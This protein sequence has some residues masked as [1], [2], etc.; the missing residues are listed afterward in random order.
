MR[1]FK[2]SFI[3]VITLVIALFGFVGCKNNEVQSITIDTSNLTLTINEGETFDFSGLK[4]TAN[5]LK[6][7]A[8]IDLGDVTIDTALVDT[9]KAGEYVV[10]VSYK[11]HEEFFKVIVLAALTDIQVDTSNC[12]IAILENESLDLSA[13]K[14][15]AIYSDGTNRELTSNEYTL[16]QSA[17]V[18][19]SAGSYNVKVTYQGMEK[20][21][22]VTVSKEEVPVLQSISV[23]GA[24]NN[25][26][27]GEAFATTG[28]VVTAHYSKG[29]DK[30]VTSNATVVG[31]VEMS[32][33]GEQTVRI[34]YT[35]GGV[36]KEDTYVITIV[37]KIKSLAADV[38]GV[39]VTYSPNEELDLTGLKVVATLKDDTK[40]EL[41]GYQVA[42]L[43]ASGATISDNILANTADYTVKITYGG[44]EATFIVKARQ[45]AYILIS[46]VEEFLAMR[47]YKDANNV[48]RESYL[49]T[50]DL[51]F[52]DVE[53]SEATCPTFAGEFNGGGHKLSNITFA[54]STAKVGA[55][56]N[57]IDGGTVKNLTLFSC[58]ASSTAESIGLIG[59]LCTNGTF[60]DLEF[61]CCTV[62]TS[63]GSGYAALVAGRNDKAGTVNMKR[64]T[65]KNLT[66]VSAPKYVG[67]LIADV[68]GSST[69][70][71]N[72]VDVNITC[73]SG[74]QMGA[75]VGRAR[76]GATLNVKN[77]VIRFEIGARNETNKTGAIFDGADRATATIENVIVASCT[78]Q[79]KSASLTQS[80]LFKGQGNATVTLT[81]CFYVGDPALVVYKATTDTEIDA[82]KTY[83]TNVNGE[84][85]VVAEPVVGS[86]ASYYEKGSVDG[87]LAYEIGDTVIT[88]MTAIGF[89]FT[90]VWEAD[91]RFVVKLKGSSANLPSQDATVVKIVA[92]ANNAK[93][94]Y[95]R[96]DAFDPNGLIVIATYSD[97]VVIP[98]EESDYT[99]TACKTVEGNEVAFTDTF[100]EQEVGNY[101]IKVVAGEANAKYDIA[102]VKEVG[103]EVVAIEGKQVFRD[104][105][106]LNTSGIITFLKISDGTKNLAQA[107]QISFSVE[108]KDE[109]VHPASDALSVDSR[110]VVVTRTAGDETFTAKYPIY[111]LDNEVSSGLVVVYV[112]PET[113]GVEEG[114]LYLENIDLA[115]DYLRS[116]DLKAEVIKEIRVEKG[117]YYGAVVVDM[118]N[119]RIV[120]ANAEDLAS[121]VVIACDHASDTPK[122]NLSASFGTEGSATVTIKTSAIGFYAYGV[123]FANTFDYRHSEFT[124]KQAVALL[125][126]ADQAEFVE[127][128]FLG[129]QD[130]LEPKNGRQYYKDCYIEGAVDFIF[131]NNAIVI[132]DGCEIHNVTRY[133]SGTDTPETNQ[134]Y[135]CAPKGFSSGADTDAIEYGYVFMNCRFTAEADIPAGSVSIARPWGNQAKVAV[136]NSTLGAHISILAYDGSV[137]SRYADMSGNKPTDANVKF[138]EYN[139]TGDGAINTAVAGVTILTETEASNY[140]SAKIFGT[141]NG[142]VKY[143]EAWTLPDLENGYYAVVGLKK[144]LVVTKAFVAPTVVLVTKGEARV[145]ESTVKVLNSE[146]EEVN[147][148][149]F[150][151]TLG[152]YTLKL[153]VEETEV[154]STAITVKDGNVIIKTHIFNA[155]DL[156]NGDITTKQELEF[157]T[158]HATSNK[159][160]VDGS[161]K[162]ADGLS[163]T[164]RLKFNGSSKSEDFPNSR[165]IEFT[166]EGSAR[167]TIYALSS[168]SSDNTRKV[169]VYDRNGSA[170]YESTVDGKVLQ[171]YE[172]DLTE[173]GTY[174][175]GCEVNGINIYY[176]KVVESVLGE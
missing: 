58:Y 167:V 124:N 151:D 88:E 56:F 150:T 160:T 76:S 99:L 45:D 70:N 89:D 68:Y 38:T 48:N 102:I 136:L 35:E 77:A 128:R 50:A 143:D 49:L 111:V 158:L 95:Y 175:I 73:S 54:T 147:V 34:S 132:F 110:Y 148:N 75:L 40:V 120:K 100:T 113:N 119:V 131:G 28:L 71:I 101:Y 141:T 146:A 18:V 80:G 126:Q 159:F 17:V 118:P 105:D 27:L 64:I 15:K 92:N 149:E 122:L 59:G 163:F 9:T 19:S 57:T 6:K 11:G 65:V 3:L 96:G 43:D 5:F 108:D 24:K 135:I 168:S 84:Y 164:K 109:N 7:Q 145:V 139:N 106:E 1:I 53:W 93:K 133:K 166:T 161:E 165:Y 63:S 134:G 103:V 171:A 41:S 90:N 154:F 174:Y 87:G 98:L 67:G 127:C 66:S 2:R 61:S 10:T 52:S 156:T 94:Q 39:K 81:N 78:S 14:V 12:K 170:Q 36:T 82:D 86:I 115:L 97:G 33:E 173:A 55:L 69:L 22:T 162:S 140:T 129:V 21:F 144:E 176:V 112:K 47:N 72:D 32:R 157:Y 116:L 107:T 16:D 85:T 138:V 37:D 121:E 130:T 26:M 23:S 42:L 123:T 91:S 114:K 25:F 8:E 142:Q 137:K 152:E 13:L 155:S 60:E 83:Y 172:C 104:G 62:T 125:C 74:S 29:A 46:T 44:H 79:V 20:T 4:V 31:Q 153:F 117:T 169:V 51:D 30:D